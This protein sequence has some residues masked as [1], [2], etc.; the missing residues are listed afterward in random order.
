[1]YPPAWIGPRRSIEPFE[2]AG[3]RVPGGVHVNYCSWASHHLPDV[4]ARPR[5]LRPV[6]LHAR[7]EGA[8]CPRAPTSRS[9]AARGRAS[10]MRFGLAEIAIIAARDAGALPPRARCPATALQIRQTPT[11]SPQAR[12]A[13][14]RPRCGAGSRA[15]RR[16]RAGICRVAAPRGGAA[17]CRADLDGQRRGAAARSSGSRPATGRRTCSCPCAARQLVVNLPLASA[18]TVWCC[19]AI[20]VPGGR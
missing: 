4:F 8:R 9:A 15:G 19:Q 16:T 5:A 1:M 13:D 17:T 14:D 10:G 11:I 2:F 3:H 12:P 7:G 6:A 20:R 18:L